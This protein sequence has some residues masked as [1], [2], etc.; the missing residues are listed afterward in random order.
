[1]P[2]NHNTI[3]KAKH[4]YGFAGTSIRVMPDNTVWFYYWTGD[5]S[6]EE[7]SLLS[8]VPEPYKARYDILIASYQ[9]V[10]AEKPAKL[11]VHPWV[12]DELVS[13][14]GKPV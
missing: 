14:D 11:A 9:M 10:F 13:V 12:A 6:H 3:T 5:N 4:V 7:V 8:E 1:M 2:A